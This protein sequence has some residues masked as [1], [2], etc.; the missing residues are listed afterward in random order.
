[1]TLSRVPKYT[2][3]SG[4]HSLLPLSISPLCRTWSFSFS[5]SHL[6]CHLKASPWRDLP[7]PSYRRWLSPFNYVSAPHLFLSC[8]VLVSPTGGLL[9][10]APYIILIQCSQCLAQCLTMFTEC[11]G[12]QMFTECRRKQCMTHKSESPCRKYCSAGGRGGVLRKNKKGC[13][14]ALLGPQSDTSLLQ[15]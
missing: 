15:V 5:R 3:A 7:W 11:L 4:L 1:M 2:D 9:V 8:W 12:L 14:F 10:I 6:K 13:P